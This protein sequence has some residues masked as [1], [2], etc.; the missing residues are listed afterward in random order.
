[1]EMRL[2]SV[3]RHLRGATGPFTSQR[4]RLAL[5]LSGSICSMI[6]HGGSLLHA[7]QTAADSLPYQAAPSYNQT[8]VYRVPLLLHDFSYRMWQ[9]CSL[10]LPSTHYPTP[11]TTT[12]TTFLQI[13]LRNIV[14]DSGHSISKTRL[15]ASNLAPAVRTPQRAIAHYSACLLPRLQRTSSHHYHT[16][17]HGPT[18]SP[19][20][21]VQIPTQQCRP[22]ASTLSQLSHGS[23]LAALRR[24][25]ACAV[26]FRRLCATL[27]HA[28]YEVRPRSAE[29]Q[30][31]EPASTRGC[32]ARNGQQAR[33]L[34]AC[35]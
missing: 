30:E 18:T 17:S 21:L 35:Q 16:D 25:T 23:A 5:M 28:G 11:Q 3:I 31:I 29:R 7:L 13:P 32:R 24:G 22:Y 33:L 34:Q 20:G 4:C 15:L 12:L 10:A 2:R 9:C 6:R 1:M 8:L 27:A 26:A 14:C 19:P